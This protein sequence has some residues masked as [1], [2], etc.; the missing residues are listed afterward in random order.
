[1]RVHAVCTFRVCSTTLCRMYRY[2]HVKR[3][4][5]LYSPMVSQ[6]SYLVIE[7]TGS[8][9]AV[10]CHAVPCRAVP[11]RAMPWCGMASEGSSS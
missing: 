7:D 3:E 6:G 4:I 2:E 11:C 8:C 5:E 1:M 9:R 10:P